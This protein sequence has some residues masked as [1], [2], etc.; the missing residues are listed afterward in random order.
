ML[1]KNKIMIKQYLL[2]KLTNDELK[3]LQV[4]CPSL[5][6]QGGWGSFLWE[7]GTGHVFWFSK[8]VLFKSNNNMY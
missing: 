3:C 6:Y 4:T 8:N 7:G 5:I 1:S 2:H